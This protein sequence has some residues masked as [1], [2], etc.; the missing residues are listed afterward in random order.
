MAL[1]P[2]FSTSQINADLARFAAQHEAKFVMGLR[3][4]GEEFVNN[5]RMK[6]TYKDQTGNLRSSI[7]YG[8]F[9]DGKE[10]EL[11]LAGGS[12]ESQTSSEQMTREAGTELGK[13]IWLIV[14]AGM[15]YALWVETNGYDVLSGSRPTRDQILSMFQGVL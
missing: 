15:N 3:R 4:I 14:V 12:P 13:G 6:Q 2:M 11:K 10:V 7:G 1:I 5:A 9:K 8:I